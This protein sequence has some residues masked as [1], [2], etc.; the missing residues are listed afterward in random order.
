[1]G[2]TTGATEKKEKK[3]IEIQEVTNGE[4]G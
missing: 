4:K 2:E 1:M 3:G